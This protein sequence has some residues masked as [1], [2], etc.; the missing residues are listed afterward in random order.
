MNDSKTET[1]SVIVERN[2]PYSVDKIWQALTQ[3]AL[4]AEWLMKSD[5][6]PQIG[7]RFVF[8]ADWGSVN[9]E[10]LEIKPN[11][12]LAY[13]WAAH[14]LESI[15]TFTLVPSAGGTHLCVEQKGFRA[16]QPQFYEGAKG[17]WP[18]FLDALEHA[19]AKISR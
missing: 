3:P 4:M 2:L 5:F 9:C 8:N 13:S 19:L 16:D 10:V 15:V 17:G 14:G 1:R 12:L 6:E 7:H 11:E 18:R